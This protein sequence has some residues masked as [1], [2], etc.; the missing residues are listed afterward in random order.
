MNKKV[1]QFNIAFLI[2]LALLINVFIVNAEVIGPGTTTYTL[3]IIDI[4]KEDGHELGRNY[5]KVK[6]GGTYYAENYKQ[7][8]DGY[9]WQTGGNVTNMVSNK[10]IYSY[11]M[12]IT[13]GGGN[14]PTPTTPSSY[15]VTVKDCVDSQSGYVLG[16]GT[17]TVSAGSSAYATALRS[18][19]YSG[20]RLLEGTYSNYVSSNITLY[21]IFNRISTYA[22]SYNGNGSTSGSMSNDT[23]EVGQTKRLSSNAYSKEYTVSFNTDGGEIISPETL[24]YDFEGWALSPNGEVVYEDNQEVS[25]LTTTDGAT[26]SLYASWSLDDKTITLPNTVQKDDTYTSYSTKI[27]DSETGTLLTSLSDDVVRSYTFVG[28]NTS[29]DGSGF[30]YN[31]SFIPSSDITLFAIYSYNDTT[32]EVV[33]PNSITQKEKLVEYITSNFY[34]KD[35]LYSSSE[36]TKTTT[37]SYR[38]LSETTSSSILETLQIGSKIDP[39]DYPTLYA[40]YDKDFEY[41]PKII[42]PDIPKDDHLVVDYFV[43]EDKEDV[44]ENRL[45]PNEEIKPSS[46]ANYNAVYHYEYSLFF[47]NKKDSDIQDITGIVGG[48]EVS[49]PN[50]PKRDNDTCIG[51]YSSSNIED[52]G[53]W[54]YPRNKIVMNEDKT[55]Y[56]IWLSDLNIKKP[57]VKEMIIYVRNIADVSTLKENSIWKTDKDYYDYL[58]GVLIKNKELI[59]NYKK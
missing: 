52:V 15:T 14:T 40:R 28:W 36:S 9:S 50:Y 55:L 34:L 25:N 16:S 18:T 17:Y 12:R 32:P 10:T 49:I 19:T 29:S 7:G 30:M 26:I 58:N 59:N 41:E 51:F 35:E 57:K 53:K 37:Y 44:E 3:T 4:A 22:V 8:Y 24:S 42:V 54:Y 56:C 31:G 27:Y 43:E 33:V 47:E 23:F 11:Y 38:G 48:S 6:A 21:R 39:R 13:S 20:Y 2:M 45:Y 46:S 5:Y 1:K